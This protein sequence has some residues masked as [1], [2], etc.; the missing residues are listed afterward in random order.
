MASAAALAFAPQA[1][2]ALVKPYR[3]SLIGDEFEGNVWTTG[4]R[5]ELDDGWKTYWRNPGDAGIPPQ[6]T[7]ESNVPAD[8]IDVKFPV[9]S[10]IRDA[11]GEAIGYKH[12]VV[13]PVTVVRSGPSPVKLRL[14]LF[15]AVCKDVCIPASAEAEIELASAVM[16]PGGSRLVEQWTKSLPVAAEIV[17]AAAFESDNG[18]PVLVLTLRQAVDDIFV[19][20]A[21][22]A[23]FHAP[24]FSAD[25]TTARLPVGN[26]PD[27]SVL[28]GTVLKL[29]FKRGDGG[30]EQSLTL[31]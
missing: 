9:P 30:L 6:F 5:I 26:M 14:K 2:R 13:F 21:T 25:G 17:S 31:P 27:F 4:I 11:S 23:Y 15:L 10:R 7:W 24:V 18:K 20:T 16:D 3:V 29:T 12:E 28:R 19:E 1:A 8:A 22:S